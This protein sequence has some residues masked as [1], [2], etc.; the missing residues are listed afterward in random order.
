MSMESAWFGEVRSVLAGEPGAASWGRLC[1]LLSAPQAAERVE[2]WQAYVAAQLDERWEVSLRAAPRAWLDAALEGRPPAGWP[3]AR[4][5]VL[6]DCLSGDE[7][8][9][10]LI[11]RGFFEPFAE[12]SLA[13]C[14]L[15]AAGAMALAEAVCER[16]TS[17]RLAGNLLRTDDAWTVLSK[18]DMPRL[19]LLD[20]SACGLSAYNFE[21]LY[22][23]D[24]YAPVH[25]LILD[26]N[27][28]IGALEEMSG[29]IQKLSCSLEY[30]EELS[31]VGCALDEGLMWYLDEM[32]C[33]SVRGLDLSD[34][35]LGY[36]G[37]KCIVDGPA[38]RLRR[39][40][41]KRAQI[42]A[43]GARLLAG[44]SW[45]GSL[46]VLELDGN[47]LGEEG[48]AALAQSPYL[49]EALRRQFM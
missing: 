6:D 13:R 17:L 39:L 29:W 31:M 46:E 19:K 12:I 2:E 40:S 27:P 47:E 10:G 1:G 48:V 44:A 42:G 38:R 49:S 15:S 21:G 5:C 16:V 24:L 9:V 8:L 37:L 28:L 30:V 34:N 26:H 41:L 4:V 7:Q 3:L 14:G 18:R 25:T 43:E 23:G 22:C 45:A 11:G 36:R 35:P 20:L 33:G 32:L